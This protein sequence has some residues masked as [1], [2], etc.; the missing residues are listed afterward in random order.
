MNPDELAHYIKSVVDAA[1]PLSPRQ[2][3]Q[4]AALLAP[5]PAADLPTPAPA[6]VEN[7]LPNPGRLLV[8]QP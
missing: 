4:L 6:N 1:P 7:G 2:R 5:R 8:E 3:Q